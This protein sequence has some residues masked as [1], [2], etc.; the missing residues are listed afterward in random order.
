MEGS[1]PQK[2]QRSLVQKKTLGT[3]LNP[4]RGSK[5]FTKGWSYK[6]KIDKR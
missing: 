4:Y 1:C 2:E 6:K 5:S 3:V